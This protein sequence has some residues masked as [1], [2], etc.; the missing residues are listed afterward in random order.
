MDELTVEARTEELDRALAFVDERLDRHGCER[1]AK[2]Q[3]DVAVEEIFV[4]IARYAYPKGTGRATLRVDVQDGVAALAFI[5][6][7][8]PFDPL[9]R[10]D[11]DVTLPAE[12]R[13]IGGLGIY[14]VKKSMDS[15]SYAREDGQN[16]L[17]LRK[18]IGSGLGSAEDRARPGSRG[19]SRH[20]EL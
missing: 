7:G 3:I 20:G 11:P 9:A 14:M 4:N 10:P 1:R 13:P 15:V 16:V 2:I 8:V 18:R 17:T 6:D 12:E 19:G 5:D